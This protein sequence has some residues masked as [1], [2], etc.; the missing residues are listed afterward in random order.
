MRRKIDV[1]FLL[2]LAVV[3]VTL[4]AQIITKE[5]VKDNIHLMSASLM[6]YRAP[7]TKLTPAPKGYK[8][9]YMSHYGR[10][11]S[12]FLTSASQYERPYTILK[13]AAEDGA[14]T[15]FGL[16]VYKRL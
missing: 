8:P 5:E 10:H 9:I 13:K 4:Q 15:E 7:I 11:G 14:L 3:T 2:L 12:R 1:C 16:D 6:A